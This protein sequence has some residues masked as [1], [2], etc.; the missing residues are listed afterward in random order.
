MGILMV[1]LFQ[2]EKLGSYYWHALFFTKMLH[3]ALADDNGPHKCGRPNAQRSSLDSQCHRCN[4]INLVVND[5]EV[6]ECR[7]VF[8]SFV[9]R[10]F[11]DERVYQC[12]FR[13]VA[14]LLPIPGPSTKV[15]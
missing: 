15:G 1:L 9:G 2:I 13:M 6:N 14:P 7:V 11:R 8:N 4:L 3:L 10:G 12:E 5:G